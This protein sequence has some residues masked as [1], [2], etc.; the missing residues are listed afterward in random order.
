MIDDNDLARI[1]RARL[2]TQQTD[3]LIGLVKGALLDGALNEREASGIHQWLSANPNC[4]DEWPGRVLYERI[5]DALR[6]GKL[7]ADELADLYG[8]MLQLASPVAPTPE[9][10][11]SVMPSSLPLS[12]PPIEIA[13]R[14]RSFC[15][16]G[17]F[18][19]GTRQQCHSA[20]SERGG[21]PASAITKK[22]DYLVIGNIGSEFWL[23]SS[24]GT[25]IKK[26]VDYRD[27]GLPITIVSESTWSH[28][29]G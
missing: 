20:V 2:I 22:L 13:H 6:D 28:T 23:H 8:L 29:L 9:S 26:A 16:T 14:G 15:F 5:S 21:T 18:E 24:F 19:Y 1:H 3:E 25:K 27:A 12:S 10:K 11:L 4:R 7:D 17:V